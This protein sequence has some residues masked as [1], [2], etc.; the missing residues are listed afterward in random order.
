MVKEIKELTEAEARIHANICGD[1]WLYTYRV[2]R[3]PGELKNHPRNNIYKI[4]Y[5]IQYCNTEKLLLDRFSEDVKNIYN[6]RANASG[7]YRSIKGKWVYERLKHLGAGKSREWFVGE[8][9]LN[10]N[11]S[12]ISE[13]LKAFFDDEGHVDVESNYITLNSVNFSGLKQV[14]ELLRKIG[15]VNTSLKGPYYYKQ[16]HSYRLKILSKDIEKFSV[17]V[18]FYHPKKSAELAKLLYLRGQN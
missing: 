15:I 1:G 2:K 4:K 3:S 18:G 8:E 5:S 16:F 13:W 12:I 11:S 14:Q 9:L 7:I 6:L 10:A 17:L